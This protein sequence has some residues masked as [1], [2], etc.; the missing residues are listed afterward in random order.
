[1]DITYWGWPSNQAV[2]EAGLKTHKDDRNVM[3]S[4]MRDYVI[5]KT[6][7]MAL[8]RYGGTLDT[9]KRL[10][11]NGYPVLLERGH[12]DPDDGW[13][14]HYSIV[15]AYDDARQTVRIPDTLLGVMTLS[16]DELVLDWAH[17]DGIYLVVY[18]PEREAEVLTLLGP[19]ADPAVNLQ[20]ALDQVTARIQDVSGRNCFL[21]GTRAGVFWLRYKTTSRQLRLMTRLL[22][23]MPNCLLGNVP[24]ASPGTRWVLIRLTITLG[25][26][27]IPSTLRC[28]PSPT[29]ASP[30][31]PKPGIGLDVQQLPCE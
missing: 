19:D 25:A 14:G 9:L 28:R 11:S 1:M 16:Y 17:F 24:G 18:P 3:L 26:T 20:N 10:V 12:T 8:I 5:E 15:T 27:R 6:D 31:C 21:P 13:M 23:S 2:T 22:L 7:L 4:E 29:P 30:P